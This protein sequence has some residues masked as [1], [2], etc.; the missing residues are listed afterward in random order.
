MDG[1]R[2]KDKA[3]EGCGAEGKGFE[4]ECAGSWVRYGQGFFS[5]SISVFFFFFFFCVIF[6]FFLGWGGGGGGRGGGGVWVG[7]VWWC[8]GEEFSWFMWVGGGW[9]GEG[10]GGGR[11]DMYAW[12][13]EKLN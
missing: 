7:C 10:E 11:T 1:I 8:V 2:E 13:L 6:F 9:R 12:A 4:K 5:L 3:A